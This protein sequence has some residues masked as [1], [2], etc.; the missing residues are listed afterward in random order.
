M[1]FIQ[2]FVTDSIIAIRFKNSQ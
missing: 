2:P 1:T